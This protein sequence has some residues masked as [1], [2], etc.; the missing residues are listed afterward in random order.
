[1]KLGKY[2]E[3]YFKGLDATVLLV[4]QACLGHYAK[5]K[6]CIENFGLTDKHIAHSPLEERSRV[7]HEKQASFEYLTERGVDFVFKRKQVYPYRM[8][9]YRLCYIEPGDGTRIQ[10]ELISY[11]RNLIRSLSKRMGEQLLYID[12]EKRL[13]T[14]IATELLEKDKM[15]VLR[16][17][18]EFTQFYFTHNDDPEREM[19]LINR[20]GGI[21]RPKLK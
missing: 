10:A 9:G 15:E 6:T 2:L 18:A 3:P 14:Y 1:V 7:G 16:D 11:D 20:V 21:A 17:Y 13:D 4:G 19:A 5:F 8:T 12:F